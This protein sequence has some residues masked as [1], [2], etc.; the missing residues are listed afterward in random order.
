MRAAGRVARLQ[1]IGDQRRRAGDPVQAEQAYRRALA[2]AERRLP[3]GDVATA[4]IRNQLGVVLKYTGAFDEAAELYGQAHGALV[5]GLGA[6]HPEVATVLHNIGG[7]CHAAGRPAD[8]EA[9]ARRAVAIRERSLGTD[10]P[11]VAADRA[12]LAAILDAM[13]HHDEAA[14]LLE[15]ALAIFEATLGPDDHETAV[16]LSNLG[17]IDARRGNLQSAE[18][19]LRRALAI[20]ERTLGTD[21]IELVP[22]LGTLGV[23]CRRRGATRESR[24]LSQRALDLLLS[25]GLHSHPQATVLKTNLARLDHTT[26]VERT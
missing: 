13:G 10:H 23:V 3:R 4:R 15:S 9:P 19:R 1:R 6:E 21:H 5:R 24:E 11:D 22:T 16:T 20:K 17:A 2:I 14:D 8:G 18:R 12:A 7:L 25:R 26:D